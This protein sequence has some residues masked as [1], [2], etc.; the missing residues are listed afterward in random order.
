MKSPTKTLPASLYK[1]IVVLFILTL[2]LRV[3]LISYY[4]NNLGGIEP[5]VVYGIQRLLLGQ[6]LYQDPAAG[7]YGVMQYTPL[8]YHTVAASG[9][10]IGL[11]GLD[12]QGVYALCR[13]LALVFNLLTVGIC[14]LLIA[15]WGYSRKQAAILAMPVLI[16][17]TSHYYTRGDSMHLF[18]FTAAMYSY[19]RYIT[20]GGK[21]LHLL[22]AALLAAACFM[23]KQSGILVIGI[24]GFCLLFINRLYAQV[25]VFSLATAVFGFLIALGLTH[26]DWHSMYLNAYLGLKNGIDLGFLLDMFTSQFFIDMVPCY[27]L[28]GILV[29]LAIRRLHDA[30][31]RIL[32]AGAALS[33]LFA[34]VTG[35]KIGSSNNYLIECL[36]FVFTAMPYMLRHTAVDARLFSIAKL[37]VTYRG[38]ALFACIVL[39]SSKTM[40]FFTA[41]FI[42]KS[43]KNN[44]KEY[45]AEQQLMNYFTSELH[46]QPGEHI[47]FTERN[48]LDNL[49][50]PYAILPN[51]DVA[52]QVY[53]A[54]PTTYDYSAL[55]AGCNTGLIKYIVTDEKRNDIN[56]CHNAL[57]FITFDTSKFQLVGMRYGYA[58]YGYGAKKGM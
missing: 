13:A 58:V 56:I 10:L 9:K 6:P 12:V 22:L 45:A 49:F 52:N 19:I 41:V 14:A 39:I 4:N 35:I 20:R 40:G 26:G 8:Y 33:F 53:S 38:F 24:I 17:L 54:S 7:A 21:L 43:I 16:M 37:N 51:K 30:A 42:E 29:W 27:A 11:N 50:L 18:L 23:V 3:L 44:A 57:P 2:G 34:M 25:V 36:L 32:A 55:T 28:A 47:F 31:Y 5:N 15:S 46:L 1:Y 48:F